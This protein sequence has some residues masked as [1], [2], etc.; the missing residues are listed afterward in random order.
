MLRK[1][2]KEKNE[3]FKKNRREFISTEGFS[4]SA[5]SEHSLC[6]LWKVSLTSVEDACYVANRVALLYSSE[7]WT[8]HSR[9]FRLLKRFHQKCL[10]RILNVTWQSKTQDTEILKIAECTTIESLVMANQMPWTGHIERMEAER[11]SKRLFNGNMIQTRA[12]IYI[13]IGWVGGWMCFYGI[14]TFVVY[15]TPNPFLWK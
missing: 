15:L 6:I 8:V 2:I 1:N 7:T 5:I 3:H 11:L 9:Y 14:S 13:Y 4:I 10:R 12:Y